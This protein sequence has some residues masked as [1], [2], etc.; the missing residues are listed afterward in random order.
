MLSLYGEISSHVLPLPLFYELHTSAGQ[1]VNLE[2]IGYGQNVLNTGRVEGDCVEVHVVDD[3]VHYSAVRDVLELDTGGVLLFKLTEHGPSQHP[4]YCL[5][6]GCLSL[7]EVGRVLHED[8]P[9]TGHLGA[10]RHDDGVKLAVHVFPGGESLLLPGLVPAGAGPHDSP[11]CTTTPP[12]PH[13][14]SRRHTRGQVLH[15]LPVGGGV[16][17]E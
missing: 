4:C 16:G 5:P 14:H 13:V 9:V 3:L 10:P 17:V 15:Q 7:P 11:D 12:P 8:L 1:T 2:V 6:A